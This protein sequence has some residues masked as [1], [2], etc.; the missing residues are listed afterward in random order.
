MH[1]FPPNFLCFLYFLS[2]LMVLF[3]AQ[4]EQSRMTS[5]HRIPRL[6]NAG[7][8]AASQRPRELPRPTPLFTLVLVGCLPSFLYS[9]PCIS[10]KASPKC[11]FYLGHGFDSSTQT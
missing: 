6:K 3:Y 2:W 7:L 1:H 5:K 11:D 4:M 10:F 9:K 8:P